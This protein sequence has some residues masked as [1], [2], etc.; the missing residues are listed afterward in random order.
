[1]DGLR[2]RRHGESRRNSYSPDLRSPRQRPTLLHHVLD[3]WL[4]RDVQ[5]RLR[6][7]LQVVRYADDFVIGFEREDDARHVMAVLGK[8]FAR[9]GLRLHPEKT[10]LFQFRRPWDWESRVLRLT[11]DAAAEPD[12]A[13]VG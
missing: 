3:A 8:R 9:F 10:R 6:G 7:R 4:A 13:H 5:P 12:F 2:H 1:M 11:P